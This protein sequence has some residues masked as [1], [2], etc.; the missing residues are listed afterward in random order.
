VVKENTGYTFEPE[1]WWQPA[2]V[3][4]PWQSGYRLPAEL[5]FSAF[6]REYLR[7]I[8]VIVVATVF[9]VALPLIV[10][11]VIVIAIAVGLSGTGDND[12]GKDPTK[13][14]C[15]FEFAGTCLATDSAEIFRLRHSAHQ[16]HL[17]GGPQA[18]S[19]MVRISAWTDANSSE[20]ESDVLPRLPMILG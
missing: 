10:V 5:G 19:Q 7:R 18:S 3:W 1:H 2:F 9:F 20:V 6:V 13:D 12:T 15:K 11:V 8:A 4:E 14:Q 16:P 17:T